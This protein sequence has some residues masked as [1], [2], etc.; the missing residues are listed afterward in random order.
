[1]TFR[2]FAKPLL[3]GERNRKLMKNWI[4]VS[5]GAV[6]IFT[7]CFILHAQEAAP[8]AAA[9]VGADGEMD[10]SL[11]A[12]ESVPPMPASRLPVETHGFYSVQNPQWPPMP[13]D[14]LG[15]N[16]WS[17]GDGFFAVDDR[18][19][20]YD[21][22]QAAM[23]AAGLVR[24]M[25]SGFSPLFLTDTNDLWLEMVTVTNGVAALVIHP[26]WDQTNSVYDLRYCTNLDPPL[27]WQWLLR[28]D[29]GQTNLFVAN[30]TDAAGFYQVT[31]PNDLT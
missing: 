13:A 1:M 3:F 30:A 27:A 6:F 29:P 28:S 16:V 25:G 4:M 5:T 15:L 31:S 18:S 17:L 24:P 10:A 23:E 19:V 7:L 14:V 12:L 21:E 9:P 2:C 22:V 8:T 20:N 26:P 11:Q